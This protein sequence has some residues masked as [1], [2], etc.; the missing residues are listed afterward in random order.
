MLTT[1]QAIPQDSL[2][3]DDR[4]RETYDDLRDRNEARVIK[5]VSSLI[6]PSPE[7]LKKYGVSELQHLVFNANER[8][9]EYISIIKT[10]P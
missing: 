5:N 7:T 8:W 4:F 9:G 10:R 3:T 2:F 1:A 6:A